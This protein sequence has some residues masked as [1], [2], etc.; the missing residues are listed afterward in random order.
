[1]AK[2]SGLKNAPSTTGKPSGKGR[3]NATPKSSPTRSGNSSSK[4][5]K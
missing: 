1:M 2:S 3:G 4:V 5:K